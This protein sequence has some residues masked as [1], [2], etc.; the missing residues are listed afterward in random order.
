MYAY[1]NPT[2]HEEKATNTAPTLQRK[3]KTG[4]PNHIKAGVEHLSGVNLDNVRVNYNS[5][6]PAQLNAHAYAQGNQIH[7]GPGQSQHIAHET[8]HVAQQA[9]GR[10]APTAQ[11]AG[12]SINDNHSLEREADVMGAKAANVGRSLP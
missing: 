4:I 5:P 12:Q 7:M 11:F 3:N 1:N 10:V 6:K 2:R 9:Q 8:W